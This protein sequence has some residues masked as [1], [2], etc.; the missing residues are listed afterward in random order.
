MEDYFKQM[1]GEILEAVARVSVRNQK[2]KGA[3]S[4]GKAAQPTL[5]SESADDDDDDEDDDEE[6]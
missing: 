6:D 2:T 3:G 1:M 5:I 4:A